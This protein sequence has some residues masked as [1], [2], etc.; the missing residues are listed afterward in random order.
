[1]ASS[2]EAFCVEQI[3]DNECSDGE[4]ASLVASSVP[5]A[6][7]FAGTVPA[8]AL[9]TA[10]AASAGTAPAAW[11]GGA[12][13]VSPR[14]AAERRNSRTHEQQF[15]AGVDASAAGCESDLGGSEDLGAQHLGQGDDTEHAVVSENAGSSTTQFTALDT[16]AGTKAECSRRSWLQRARDFMLEKVICPTRNTVVERVHHSLIRPVISRATAR[17][18]ATDPKAQ[19]TAIGAAGGAVAMGTA[20][21]FLGITSGCVVG[22]LV[23]LVPAAFTFGLSIPIGAVIG[24]GAGLCV[25]TAV[26]G[27]AGLVAGGAAGYKKDDIRSGT[28]KALAQA[29]DCAQ[30]ARGRASASGRFV[31]STFV[32]SYARARIMSGATEPPSGSD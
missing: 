18:R 32:S 15:Q 27:S 25:G 3:G 21:G 17:A 4:D 5:K 24:G 20:G 2:A 1:M 16:P 26:G 31:Q 8:A 7:Q 6:N 9:A 22:A 29:G 19:S 23:G 12:Y 30:S 13:P 11:H 14:K 28:T 10:L